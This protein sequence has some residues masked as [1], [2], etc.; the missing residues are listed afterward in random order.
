MQTQGRTQ[1]HLILHFSSAC[2]RV[3]P[4][5]GHEGCRA[6]EQCTGSSL[7]PNISVFLASLALPLPKFKYLIW[8]G[9]SFPASHLITQISG[10]SIEP[11]IWDSKAKNMTPL[12]SIVCW[13]FLPWNSKDGW[14]GCLMGR[15]QGIAGKM[16]RQILSSD[17]PPCV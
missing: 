4:T 9:E 6:G 12:L 16:Y 13:F 17:F 11:G 1:D 5:L 15:K 3:L 10:L 2:C 7:V 14:L 8:S